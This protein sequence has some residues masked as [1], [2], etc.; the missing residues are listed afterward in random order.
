MPARQR[1]DLEGVC[2]HFADDAVFTLAGAKEASPVVVRCTDCET[3]RQVMK[4]L[5]G[6]F[7]FRDIEILSMIVEGP[8]IAVHWR[9]RARATPTGQ[10]AVT[11][12]AD[13]ITLRDGK[14]ASFT[15][16]CDTAL[17]AKMLGV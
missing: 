7:E 12:L 6:N 8:K 15:E 14:I 17:A 1:G 5:I 3:L 11:E 4:G 10:E 13:I 2:R 16:F 9:A